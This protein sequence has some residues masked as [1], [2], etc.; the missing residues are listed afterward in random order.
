[1][2]GA[3]SVK[4]IITP[5]GNTAVR[6]KIFIRCTDCSLAAI[7]ADISARGVSSC[8]DR[9]LHQ[10]RYAGY[11]GGENRDKP[12]VSDGLCQSPGRE[13]SKT[14]GALSLLLLK[15]PP[16]IAA[17]VSQIQDSHGILRRFPLKGEERRAFLPPFFF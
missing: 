16:A 11:S 9:G 6:L 14:V 12:S 17:S 3:Q 5:Q 1:M 2:Y 10:G 15:L 4:D 8:F 13:Q 7:A